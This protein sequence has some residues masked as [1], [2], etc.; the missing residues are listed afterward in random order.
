MA[1]DKAGQEKRR[2]HTHAGRKKTGRRALYV[3]DSVANGD[4]CREGGSP[5]HSWSEEHC[6]ELWDRVEGARNKLV[7]IINP[8]K[9]T[10]Y[11]RQCKVIDEQDEDEVLNSSRLRITKAGRLLDILGCQG[12]RGLQAFMESLELYHPEQYT[13]LTGKRATQRC[14]L[15]LDEEGP[16][17]LTQFLLVEV[18]QL[19]QQLQKSQR[20]E[21]SVSRRC[22]VAEDERREL[23]HDRQVLQRLQKDWESA[24]QEVGKLKD[25]HLEQSVKYS[26]VLEEQNTQKKLVEELRSRLTEA[27]TQ[28]EGNKKKSVVSTAGC[29][30][31]HPAAERPAY[32]FDLPT[33]HNTGAQAVDLEKKALMDMMHQDCL[34]AADKRQE[35]CSIITRLQGEIWSTEEHRDKLQSQCEQ[36]QLK[37]KALQLD[38]EAEQR[39]SMSYFQQNIDLKRERD[40]A[41]CSR[42]SLHLEYTNCLLDKDC[43]RKRNV[44]LQASLDQRQHEL[45]RERQK[46]QEQLEKIRPCLN[47]STLSLNIE[48]Q[49]DGPC[50]SLNLDLSLPNDTHPNLPKTEDGKK[51]R[52]L[53]T[54]T[55]PPCKNSFR[56]RG[57]N[58]ALALDSCSSDDNDNVAGEEG[59]PSLM[60]SCSSVHSHFFPPDLLSLP[61]TLQR[62]HGGSRLDLDS[63]CSDD[64]DIMSGDQSKPSL[65]DSWSSVH[66]HYFPP[67][68]VS[69]PDNTRRTSRP[70]VQPVFPTS[71]PLITPGRASL[72]DDL[73]IIGG[74]QT[75]I[76]VNY[77]KAG[78]AAELCG[79]KEGSEL[80]ELERVLLGGG[81]VVFSQCTAEVAHLS[82][83]WWTE[84][85]A[86][87]HQSNQEAYARLCARISLSTFNGGD[88][89]YVRVN[90]NME[91]LC[92]PSYLGVSCDD[93]IHVTDTRHNGKYSWR[94]CLVDPD[95]ASPLQAGD[96]PNYDRAQQLLMFLVQKNFKQKFKEKSCARVR[97]VQAVDPSC[98]GV[99]PK[100]QQV[101]YTLNK[102]HEDHF[103][104]YSLV[105]PMKVHTK[106][107]V[108]FS[109]SLLSRGL[110]ERLLKRVESCLQYNTCV[111]ET[112]PTSERSDKTIFLLD[113]DDEEPALGIRLQSIQDA[114]SQDKHCLLELGLSCVEALLRQDICPI[115]IHILPKT[116]KRKKLRKFISTRKRTF[117]PRFDESVMEDVCQTEELQLQSLPLLYHTLDSSTWSCT[118]ELLAAI[119]NAITRQ[120][121]A[122][123][124]LEADRL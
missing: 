16:Q 4:L 58:A 54:Y 40:E 9:L 38:W 39:R 3:T 33:T 30:C 10:P 45:Q 43:L 108:I 121:M 72:V 66:S 76:F 115:V 21:R 12:Q 28:A 99:T 118:E 52:H 90:L 44:Q 32:L 5:S 109:P 75:G 100:Q 84:P 95:S 122:L 103:I 61:G 83:Q 64:T 31:P 2:R 69:L 85:S 34:E 97:L 60:D 105:Q 112:I 65:M 22:Q 70:R 51:E 119:H 124:W 74:N 92:D 73:T 93:I 7:R 87:K 120:Q 1:T 47:C 102:R 88:S 94:C 48:E 89:F 37:V 15:I 116:K 82:L 111:P 11:L 110:I 107:P 77:V 96:M 86:L 59:K 20:C 57:Q 50:C 14:S 36:L 80:L 46:S 35:L 117:F 23:R 13:K 6:K 114:I 104:P 18:R 27:E 101:L 106:R 56:K 17:V 55:F 98:H 113:S 123:A 71:G 53:S 29:A 81:S 26:R 24:C 91:A 78:S 49:C 68:L 19:R 41:L 79:L 42:Y 62:I 67:D 25:R 8:A 63:C